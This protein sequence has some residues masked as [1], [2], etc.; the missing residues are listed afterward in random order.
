MDGLD[1]VLIV[2]PAATSLN[3]STSELPEMTCEYR[4]TVQSHRH[5]FAADSSVT[6]AEQPVLRNKGGFSLIK[7]LTGKR[8]LSSSSKKD[9]RPQSQAS[10]DE[11]SVWR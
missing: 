4:T 11:S 3:S 6:T 1:E 2:D 9:D 8:P 5:S 10:V 7:R